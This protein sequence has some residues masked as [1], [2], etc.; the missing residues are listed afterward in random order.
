MLSGERRREGEAGQGGPVRARLSSNWAHNKER[1]GKL[2][3]GGGEGLG[4]GSGE[5]SAR[6]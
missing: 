2:E 6:M 5:K 4:G 1:V 3:V